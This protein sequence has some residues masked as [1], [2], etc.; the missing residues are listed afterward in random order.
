MA[1]NT[2][3][4]TF[5]IGET[6]TGTTSGATGKIIK[7]TGTVLNMVDIKGIFVSAEALTGSISLAT[8]VVNGTPAYTLFKKQC[9]VGDFLVSITQDEVHKI[10][11][12]SDD[13]SMQIQ[14]PFGTDLSSVP[15]VISPSVPRPRKI[16]ISNMGGA[17]GTI[18]GVT[19]P[20][21]VSETFSVE[22]KY[23]NGTQVDPIVCN[24]TGTT[25]MVQITY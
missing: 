12:I 11:F 7:D 3:V 24:A 10:T 8:A 1:Y 14:E 17:S 13:G 19:F 20:A 5:Q 21:G 6:V 25:F 18:D 15:I 22:D 23:N 4:N 9:K 16:S 2:L